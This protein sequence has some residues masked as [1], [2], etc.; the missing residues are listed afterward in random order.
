MF[1]KK[2]KQKKKTWKYKTHDEIQR[3][4]AMEFLKYSSKLYVTS[5]IYVPPLHAEVF[6][7]DHA[8]KRQ[9]S[10]NVKLRVWTMF[11]KL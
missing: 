5:S 11:M 1:F 7:E 3:L 8:L 4:I 6:Q 10:Y 9:T 2:L